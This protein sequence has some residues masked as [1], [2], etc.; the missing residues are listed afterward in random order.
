MQS[1]IVA[2]IGEWNYELFENQSKRFEGNWHFVNSP[3]RLEKSLKEIT[4]RYIFFPH[5]RWIVPETILNQY[6]CVCFHMTDV[7]YGRGGSPLQNLIL[8]GIKDTV[9]SALRMEKGLDTG[10]VYMK[11]PLNLEGSAHE[12]YYRSSQIVWTMIEKLV[13]ENPFPTPQI[14]E[15][16]LFKRRRPE[17]SELPIE[18]TA[19]KLYDFIRMLDADGYP[20]A[21]INYGNFQIKLN[22]AKLING[23][24]TAHAE[25]FFRETK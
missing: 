19:E 14:G 13:L 18:D 1:Y 4:P 9:I 24:L 22:Q 21:F 16:V 6:E 7:P 8:R 3:E 12:I 2:S 15:P 11:Y 20:N 17:E 23:K 25:F 5:W 10:P